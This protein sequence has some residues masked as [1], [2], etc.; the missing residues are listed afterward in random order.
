MKTFPP[1]DQVKDQAA[2]YVAQKAQSELIT[3]LHAG[4]KIERFDES[5]RR[6]PPRRRPA[7]RR[8]RRR[9]QAQDA[10]IA[11]ASRD[12]T[13]RGRTPPRP[14]SRSHSNWRLRR[15]GRSRPALPARAEEISRTAADRGR[16]LRH[17]RGRRALRGPHRRDAGAVRRAGA[18]RGR[19]H[20]LEMPFGAGRLVPRES[21]RAARRA[22]WSSIPATPTP[23]PA[24]PA[25]S[26][27][28]HVAE[29]AAKA[30]GARAGRDL[31]GLDRRDRRAAGR[32]PR[33][34]ARST[35]WSPSAKPDAL[36][37]AARAIMTTDTFPRSPPRTRSSATR[38]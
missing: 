10:L 3:S 20:P 18:G 16:A 6:P 11:A 24:T 35:R 38:R 26:A 22:R 13:A 4:R 36:M 9:R 19:V 32:R 8:R 21:A 17:R 33:S 14:A 5:S 23:S 37:D 25:S 2:R 34:P 7:R 1:F 15:H 29:A 31:H 12:A 30:I 28:A 27:V